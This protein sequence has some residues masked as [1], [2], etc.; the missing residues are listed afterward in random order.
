MAQSPA[1]A[2]RT[3][4]RALA[5][6]ECACRPLIVEAENSTRPGPRS[7]A[8]HGKWIDQRGQVSLHTCFRASTDTLTAAG[9]E[10][11]GLPRHSAEV[12]S[13]YSHCLSPGRQ[14]L[15]VHSLPSS[16]FHGSAMVTSTERAFT[17][18]KPNQSPGRAERSPG[19]PQVGG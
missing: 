13:P 16:L 14:P 3:G 18:P 5:R 4:V 1:L 15:W 11:W 8:A 2:W 6:R 9:R 10:A 17:P 12:G 7:R 19:Q